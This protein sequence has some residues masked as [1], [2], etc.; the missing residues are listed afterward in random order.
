MVEDAGVVATN[1]ITKRGEIKQQ[2][3]VTTEDQASVRREGDDNYQ[4]TRSKRRIKQDLE[5]FM[6][7]RY[8]LKPANPFTLEQLVNELRPEY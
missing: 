5:E 2:I 3:S 1:K 7:E 4:D 6:S 8:G